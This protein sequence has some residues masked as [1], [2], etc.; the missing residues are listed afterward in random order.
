MIALKKNK[1]LKNGGFYYGSI[2]K[3]TICKIGF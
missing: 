1:T 3:K 2:F